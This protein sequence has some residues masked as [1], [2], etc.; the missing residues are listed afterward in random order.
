MPDKQQGLS[1]KKISD[2]TI[3]IS[4]VPLIVACRPDVN[5]SRL[6]RGKQS[7]DYEEVSFTSKELN[8]FANS[9]QQ[10]SEE[11]GWE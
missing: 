10:R 8:K 1:L 7:E 6:L 2:K 3:L 4:Q 9:L 11:H 5:T